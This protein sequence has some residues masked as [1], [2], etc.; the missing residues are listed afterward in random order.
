[1]GFLTTKW[2]GFHCPFEATVPYQGSHACI[3][4]FSHVYDAG[5]ISH[6]AHEFSSFSELCGHPD[7]HMEALLFP[8]KS[9]INYTMTAFIP[10]T[11]KQTR[12]PNPWKNQNIIHLKWWISRLRKLKKKHGPTNSANKL[13][14]MSSHLKQVIQEAKHKNFSLLNYMKAAPKIFGNYISPKWSQ[15]SPSYHMSAALVQSY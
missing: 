10:T 1:M 9:V 6:L 4:N 2:Q 13:A 11:T 14:D 7:I 8:F 15:M 5:V 3:L 12:K